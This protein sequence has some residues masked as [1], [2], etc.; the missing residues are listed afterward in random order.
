MDFG[1][2]LT[3]SNPYDIFIRDLKSLE[4][5]VLKNS[6]IQRLLSS[7]CTKM[8]SVLVLQNGTGILCFLMM[9][10]ALNDS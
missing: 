3:C 1:A 5:T 2:F 7:F 8:K 4:S 10:Q 6:D 9:A